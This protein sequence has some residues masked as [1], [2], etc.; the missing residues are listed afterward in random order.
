MGK[1]RFEENRHKPAGHDFRT[2]FYRKT[3][4]LKEI[5]G[6]VKVREVS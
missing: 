3:G 2:D 6:D 1:T 4:S 5:G